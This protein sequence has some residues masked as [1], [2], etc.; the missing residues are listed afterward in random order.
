MHQTDAPKLRAKGLYYLDVQAKEP[1]PAA[2][3]ARS[4]ANRRESRPGGPDA[5]GRLVA[6]EPRRHDP[7]DGGADNRHPEDRQRTMAAVQTQLPQ[8]IGGLAAA[9][10]QDGAYQL[11]DV[12]RIAAVRWRANRPRIA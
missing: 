1:T 3:A 9:L 7:R 6:D 5:P 12:R 10:G 8:L 4:A 11:A 2:E